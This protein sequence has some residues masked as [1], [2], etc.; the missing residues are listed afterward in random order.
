MN[1]M[2]KVEVVA[3]PA[4]GWTLAV[5]V[6]PESTARIYVGSWGGAPRKRRARARSQKI[7]QGGGR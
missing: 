4:G 2:A 5:P 1:D 6:A 3:H 7:C